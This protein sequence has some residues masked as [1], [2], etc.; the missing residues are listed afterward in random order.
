MILWQ[1]QKCRLLAEHKH[2]E[3]AYSVNVQVHACMKCRSGILY[4]RPAIEREQVI[5]SKYRRL[6]KAVY[7]ETSSDGQLRDCSYSTQQLG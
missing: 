6:L 5:A 7:R 3:N 4:V 2:L 1:L